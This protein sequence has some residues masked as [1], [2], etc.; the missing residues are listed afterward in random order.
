MKLEFEKGSVKIDMSSYVE[1]VLG[2]FINLKHYQGP[3]YKTLSTID[4]EPR[5]WV[6]MRQSVFILS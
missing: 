1:K 5:F 2:D 4:Q 3:V 6:V